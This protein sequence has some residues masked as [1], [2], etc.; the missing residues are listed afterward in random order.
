MNPESSGRV[1]TE[2]ERKRDLLGE[3]ENPREWGKIFERGES[4]S[5]P[6]KVE[7]S[8]TSRDPLGIQKNRSRFFTLGVEC[9]SS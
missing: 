7:G 4:P 8:S 3:R 1:Q 2:R 5:P 9:N 6:L